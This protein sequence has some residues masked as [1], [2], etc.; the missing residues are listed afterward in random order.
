MRNDVVQ[1][2]AVLNLDAYSSARRNVTA[3]DATWPTKRHFTTA[4]QTVHVNAE[5][6]WMLHAANAGL[7]VFDKQSSAADYM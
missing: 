1:S 3:N 2:H 5:C 6:T 7:C 4:T